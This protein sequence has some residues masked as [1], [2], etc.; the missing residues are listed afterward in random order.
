MLIKE[1]WI[2]LISLDFLY[3][4]IQSKVQSLWNTKQ[5]FKFQQTN[6]QTHRAQ[7][8]KPFPS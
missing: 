1:A 7:C 2:S 8:S 4:E 5:H 6:I 3:N